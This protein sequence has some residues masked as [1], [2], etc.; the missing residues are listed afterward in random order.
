MISPKYQQPFLVN[1]DIMKS[2]N[3][4]YQLVNEETKLRNQVAELGS[5]MEKCR[6]ENPSQYI[7]E[8][9]EVIADAETREIIN[10]FLGNVWNRM[11]G[12]MTPGQGNAQTETNPYYSDI[13]N[14]IRAL[15]SVQQRMDS[16]GDGRIAINMKSGPLAGNRFNLSQYLAYLTKQLQSLSVK[17]PDFMDM[18]KLKQDAASSG[19][20]PEEINN[21]LNNF[22]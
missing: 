6:I 17:L 7:F 12:A 11:K 10:E 15:Q 18:R 22:R 1:G 5:L 2:F 21:A 20:S 8:N 3:E 9:L 19:R 13:W 4:F 14:A 16:S